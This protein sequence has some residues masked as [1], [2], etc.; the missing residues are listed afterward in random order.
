M[1]PTTRRAERAPA[2]TCGAS[3][4]AGGRHT[5]T[6]GV[7]GSQIRF[8]K[9]SIAPAKTLVPSFASERPR[10]VTVTGIE[11]GIGIGLP[12]DLLGYPQPAA[13]TMAV[14]PGVELH[15]LRPVG[16]VVHQ[17]EVLSQTLCGPSLEFLA[18]AVAG[19]L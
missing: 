2:P 3:E 14:A 7:V 13:S 18:A 16:L 8:C 6:P 15:C 17:I 19:N 1:S 12:A 5:H 10:G 11:F 4:I 9:T